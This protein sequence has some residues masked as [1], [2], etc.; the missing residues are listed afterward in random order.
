MGFN[1]KPQE[2]DLEKSWDQSVWDLV[3]CIPKGNV[4][5]YGQLARMLGFPRRARHVGFALGHLPEKSD[6]PWQRVINSSGRISFP[7]HT[8][9]FHYQKQ[10]LESEGVTFSPAGR[11]SLRQFG[12]QP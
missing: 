6:I 12:W 8:P 7:E 5:T 3:A 11:I 4:T 9:R 2:D 10:L 1:D